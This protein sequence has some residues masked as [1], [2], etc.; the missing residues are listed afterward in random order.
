MC[1]GGRPQP[2]TLRPASHQ[3]D[4]QAKK[5]QTETAK[6]WTQPADPSAQAISVYG[7]DIPK[8]N[9][10]H[11]VSYK[12]TPVKIQYA[13]GALH[14]LSTNL[15]FFNDSLHIKLKDVA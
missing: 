6:E 14:A 10:D 12:A 4:M 9:A 7:I 13:D 11:F 3:D 1:E 5:N 15:S 2:A 8:L